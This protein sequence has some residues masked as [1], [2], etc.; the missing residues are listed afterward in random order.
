VSSAEFLS[1]KCHYAESSYTTLCRYT[2]CHYTVCVAALS[3]VIP[4]VTVQNVVIPRAVLPIVSAPFLLH[5]LFEFGID[6]LLSTL[7]TSSP[8]KC[9]HSWFKKLNFCVDQSLFCLTQDFV[10][11]SLSLSHT[12]THTHTIKQILSDF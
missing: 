10:S 9:L 1:A 2:K 12:H 5:V 3:V 4:R 6:K 7:L 8:V 11:F